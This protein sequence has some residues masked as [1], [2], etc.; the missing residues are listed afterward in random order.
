MWSKQS[1]NVMH[2]RFK[3]SLESSLGRLLLLEAVSWQLRGEGI[4]RYAAFCLKLLK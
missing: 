4:K 3:E 2:L 1:R